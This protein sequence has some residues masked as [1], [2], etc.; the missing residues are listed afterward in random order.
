MAV[1]NVYRCRWMAEN[2]LATTD[3]LHNIDMIQIMQPAPS[4]RNEDIKK[5]ANN[6][7]RS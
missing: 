4:K 3:T 2:H 1:D 5:S 7:F 6:L